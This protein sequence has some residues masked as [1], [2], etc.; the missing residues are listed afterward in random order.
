MD[1]KKLSIS[2]PCDLL[3]RMDAFAG[4]NGMTRSGLISLAVRS[5][6][7]AVEAMPSVNKVFAAFG[8]VADGVISGQLSKDAASVKLE[9]IQASYAGLQE[10][11]SL[12]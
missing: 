9:D 6:M 12:K 3:E 11:L 7:N 5:Y 1:T 8:A 10:K 4:D 2:L